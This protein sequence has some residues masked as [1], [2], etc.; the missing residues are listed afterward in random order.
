M[1]IEIHNIVWGSSGGAT[2]IGRLDLLTEALAA[3]AEQPGRHPY[4]VPVDAWSIALQASGGDVKMV[5]SD[6]VDDDGAT[7]ASWLIADGSKEA[8]DGRNFAGV[9]MY[10]YAEEGTTL[11]IRLITR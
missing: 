4:S 11:Q 8:F 10:F 2:L 6:F 3:N 7:S 5:E 1:N 9:D